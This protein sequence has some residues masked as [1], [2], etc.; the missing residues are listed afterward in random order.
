MAK[1]R[2]GAGGDVHARGVL[3]ARMDS[4]RAE[5]AQAVRRDERRGGV[6]PF[7]AGPRPGGV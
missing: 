6:L 4:E 3:A 7:A 2:S 5:R 1:V